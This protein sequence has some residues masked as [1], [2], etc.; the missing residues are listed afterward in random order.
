MYSIK[1]WVNGD[2]V[3]ATRGLKSGRSKLLFRDV[4]GFLLVLCMVLSEAMVILCPF[5]FQA[6]HSGESTRLHLFTA[7]LERCLGEKQAF[8][9][10]RSESM[11]S[12]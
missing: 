11:A 4:G 2:P 12:S 1:F 7:E 6:S 3:S 8:C 10:I 9:A 5:K